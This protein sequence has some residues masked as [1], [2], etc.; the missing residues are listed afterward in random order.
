MAAKTAQKT[1]L[2]LPVPGPA[3]PNSGHR[4]KPTNR[5]F[6]ALIL[7]F[8][9]C[10]GLIYIPLQ[11]P[12][13]LNIP[14][15]GSQL[16]N[17]A[18]LIE[19]QN[20]AVAS[21]NVRCSEMGVKIMKEG[22]NAVDAAVTSSLCIGVVNMFSAGIGGGG[23][24]TIRVPPSSANSTSE[25]FVVDF[26]E[27]APS[28]ANTTMFPPG[29][30]SSQFGGLS[31]AVPGEIRGLAEAHRRWGHLPWEQTVQPVAELAL[32]WE[33]DVELSRR[34]LLFSNLMLNN[35]D[36]SAVFAPRG[37][38]LKEGDLI[39]RTNLSRTL[40]II[41]SEGPDAFYKG[42][43]ADSL[44][45]KIEATGGIV[46]NADLEN[47]TVN[48]YPAL[49]GNYLGKKIYVPDAPTSGP[50]ILH[51]L[52]I[53]ERYNLN[54]FTGVNTHR[55]VE[56]MKFGFAAR[57]RISDPV[58]R[59]DTATI[60]EIRTK[61]FADAIRKNLT[62]DRTHP[63]EYYNPLFDMPEDHGTSHV[64]VID[65][66][67]MAVSLTH[68][69]NTVFASQVLDAETGIILNNEMD[70]FSVPGT[71]N[72]FGLYPSPYNYPEPGKR[73]LSSTVPTIME[74]ADG[75]FYL[76]VGGSGGSLIFTA[77]L[78]VFLH[79]LNGMNLLEAVE[80]GRLHDQ[81]YPPITIA[82]DIYPENLL[83]ALRERGHNVTVFDINRVSSVVN[84]VVQEQNGTIFA[85]SDGRKNGIAAGY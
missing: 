36:W 55:L 57:T 68:T 59:N 54:E 24:L 13:S 19:A 41:A 50:V 69:V 64:S 74:N 52:N 14:K 16:R 17:P 25:V 71:P 7:C 2:P 33:V 81:L 9:V 62:D 23:F 80:Y 15:P 35:P 22:G 31:V 18:Y 1:E 32:G 43:I 4:S 6:L 12:P 67:G 65:K 61:A 84:I 20:G 28:L 8:A 26:R 79:T 27:T 38:L 53:L 75:S 48:V 63:A 11:S 76:A 72:A 73:P 60:H 46:S 30:N 29:G 3:P 44:I 5:L 83:D 78:Q 51:M 56:T 58:F 42:P 37:T 10:L 47:Y 77:I 21:E 70:D 45:R 40:S 49:K 39:R 34:M 85:V 66:A 82:D